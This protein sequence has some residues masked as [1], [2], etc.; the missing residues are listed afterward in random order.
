MYTQNKTQQIL[1]KFL[2]STRVLGN[3]GTTKVLGSLGLGPSNLGL[4]ILRQH[5]G[6][7]HAT[8]TEWLMLSE[9]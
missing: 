9:R 8:I 3:L 4:L 6:Y 5:E 1:V 2:V 7:M